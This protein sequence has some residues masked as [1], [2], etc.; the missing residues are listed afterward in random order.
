MVPVVA[1]LG[2]PRWSGQAIKIQ[3]DLGGPLV[4]RKRV[5]FLTFVATHCAGSPLASSPRCSQTCILWRRGRQ[6]A[7]LAS[8]GPAARHLAA[9][10]GAPA[11]LARL[12]KVDSAC[13][14]FFAAYCGMRLAVPV[15]LTHY[16]ALLDCA[17][18]WGGS[19]LMRPLGYELQ[20]CRVK[21]RSVS[22]S[23]FRKR[24]AAV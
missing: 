11:A 20:A 1:H 5:L 23:C 21:A 9:R 22:Q 19:L 2:I 8:A 16:P 24:N 18:A 7:S 4:P 12:Q 10:I 13:L 15:V 14:I 17:A 3:S 6:T